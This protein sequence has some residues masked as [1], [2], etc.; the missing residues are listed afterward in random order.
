MSGHSK[1]SSIKHK[2]AV[3]DA[4]KGQQFTKMAREI[5]IAAREGGGNPDGNHRLRLAMEK[6]RSAN[7]PQDNVQRAI[8]RGTGELGGAQI[9]Q[10]RFEGY[11]PHGVAIMVETVTD[12]RNRTSSDIRNLFTR[13]G[14]NLGATGSVGWMF[15]REGQIVVDA[16]GKDPEEIG[17]EAIE[18]GATDARVDGSTVEVVTDPARLEPVRDSLRKK[19][20]KVDSAEVTMNSS[21]V[22]ELDE[23]RAPGVLKLLDSLEEHDDVQSVYSNIEVPADVMERISERV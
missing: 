13:A 8:K 12:N 17:L 18:L 22:V 14:G 19:G 10:L 6:A 4:R 23:T 15:T 7:M 11:G 20:F 2:K 9:E 1:W 5:T 16:R 3:T 21:Q